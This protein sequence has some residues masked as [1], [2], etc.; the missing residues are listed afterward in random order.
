MAIFAAD[1]LIAFCEGFVNGAWEPAPTH[2]YSSTE[3]LDCAQSR[4]TMQG[5]DGECKSGFPTGMT[6]KRGVRVQAGYIPP[7]CDEAARVC[8]G[9]IPPM[10]DETARGRAGYVP[11]FAKGC[12]GWGTRASGGLWEAGVLSRA[13]LG[14]GLFR[15]LGRWF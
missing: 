6:S 4:M 14:G 3:I 12:E 11:P 2:L 9:Y 1:E 13:S 10:C 8:A 7:M 15:L 5:D